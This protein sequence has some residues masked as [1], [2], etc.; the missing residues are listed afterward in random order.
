MVDQS[1]IEGIQIWLAKQHYYAGEPITG[2]VTVNQVSS[3]TADALN[4]NFNGFDSATLWRK[5]IYGKRQYLK[6]EI[7]EN[8][9]AKV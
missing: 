5:H 2:S 6:R 8:Q 9:F 7:N 3:I 1:E 4:L